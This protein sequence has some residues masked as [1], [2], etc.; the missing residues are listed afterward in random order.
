LIPTSLSLFICSEYC[1]FFVTLTLLIHRV[2]GRIFLCHP[3]SHN[4]IAMLF[5]KNCKDPGQ[6]PVSY[7]CNLASWEAEIGTIT[8]WTQPRQIVHE[9][10]SSKWPEQNGLELWLKW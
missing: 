10:S 7:V 2:K 5:L 9:T 6:T 4:Q 3:V 1:L 8:V